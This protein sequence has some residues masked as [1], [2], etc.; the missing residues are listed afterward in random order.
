[1]ST[2]HK[3]RMLAYSALMCAVLIASTLWLKFIIPSTGVLFTTQVLFVLLCGQVLPPLYCLATVGAYIALGLMGLPVFSAT[4]G[5]AVVATPSFGYLF[6]FPLAAMATSTAVGKLAGIKA[7]RIWASGLGLAVVYAVALPYIAL[8]SGFYF[9]VPLPL[10]TL[11]T[12][13]C[14]VFLPMDII[15]GLLAALL[16]GRLHKAKVV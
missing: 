15:K 12:S 3:V 16:G 1:M 11:L 6:S 4:Q 13:Y 14:L 5:L 8:L 9:H 10:S 7:G 2:S